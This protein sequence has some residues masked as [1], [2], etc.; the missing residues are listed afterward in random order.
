MFVGRRG[1]K[2][3]PSVSSAA[4]LP[5]HH[6]RPQ[7]PRPPPTSPRRIPAGVRLGTAGLRQPL[8]VAADQPGGGS[9][10]RLPGRAA[11][12]P[13]AAARSAA[14]RDAP[15]AAG[16]HPEAGPSSVEDV[17]VSSRVMY[18]R[19]ERRRRTSTDDLVS[20]VTTAIQKV[21]RFVKLFFY[22]SL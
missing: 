15:P 17:Q 1:L 12:R 19:L 8:A 7:Q 21:S 13:V 6:G 14:A 11:G 4:L 3:R 18:S 5:F 9:L 20:T 16:R 2:L 10:D 22:R